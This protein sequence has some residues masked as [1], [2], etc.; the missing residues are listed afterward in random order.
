[1]DQ[2]DPYQILEKS[3]STM[4]NEQLIKIYNFCDREVYIAVIISS[5]DKILIKGSDE[6]FSHLSVI[7][8]SE[9]YKEFYN[10]L[11]QIN[12]FKRFIRNR[13]ID[14]IMRLF[15]R[16]EKEYTLPILSSNL[17]FL[18]SSDHIPTLGQLATCFS[19]T[20]YYEEYIRTDEA[21]RAL[22]RRG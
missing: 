5:F 10:K 21:I 8:L 7:L 18:L 11:W 14:N 16:I 2:D 22:L 6:L 1:M 17:D 13:D 9:D 12:E 15:V 4:D 20:N 3:I 19:H